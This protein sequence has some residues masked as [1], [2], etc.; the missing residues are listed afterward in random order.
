MKNN[1]GL[2][3]FNRKSCLL[4]ASNESS[5]MKHEIIPCSMHRMSHRSWNMKSFVVRWTSG[6][7]GKRDW[8]L[9]SSIELVRCID[10]VIDHGTWKKAS[11]RLKDSWFGGLSFDMELHM[12]LVRCIEWIIEHETWNHS[13]FDPS[14]ESWNM[15]KHMKRH[16]KRHMEK[17]YGMSHGTSSLH[18]MSHETWN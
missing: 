18:R 13:L 9:R 4:H 5:N 12:E 1:Q 16:M 8:P 10:W 14:N 7:P 15:K 2:F 3:Q 6:R 11:R 17:P